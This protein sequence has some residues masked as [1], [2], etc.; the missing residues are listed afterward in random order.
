MRRAARCLVRHEL[1]WLW[2][3]RANPS[4]YR[5]GVLNATGAPELVK[6]A[7]DVQLRLRPDIALVDLT[8]IADMANDASSP[9]LGK[10]EILA[11][12]TL[13]ADQPHDIW[14]F[15]FQRLVDVL[16][17]YAKFLGVDHRV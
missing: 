4:P 7:R 6:A 8:V 14:L 1:D 17:R 2:S 16:G 11:V 9:V 5:R 10:S 13:G 3:N 12:T 15:G